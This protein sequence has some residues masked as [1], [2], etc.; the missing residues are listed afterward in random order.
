[1]DRADPS[2][3]AA[4][5]SA[6]HLRAD[7]GWRG[8]SSP[9]PRRR[10]YPH[11]AASANVCR[12]RPGEERRGGQDDGG[13]AHA[14][15]LVLAASAAPA[16]RARILCRHVAHP[17]GGDGDRGGL[18]RDARPAVRWRAAGRRSCCGRSRWRCSRS[19]PPRSTIGVASAAGPDVVFA[20]LLGVRRGPQR[21]V[22]GRRRA[23][24][25]VPASRGCAGRRG[26]CSSS[27]WRSRSRVLRAGARSI[28]P[29]WRSACPRARRC[30][31]TA[32]PRTGCRSCSPIPAFFI[33]VGGRA[34]VGVADARAAR[35]ARSLRRHA[36]DRDRR[37]DRRGRARRSR[38]FGQV[39]G[40]IVTLVV[41]IAV[42]FWGFLRASK[43]VVV[44][45]AAAVAVD[46]SSLAR[47]RPGRGLPGRSRFRARR[48]E[49]DEQALDRVGVDRDPEQD[50]TGHGNEVAEVGRAAAGRDRP[51]P[52]RRAVGRRWNAR[53]P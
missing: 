20:R 48:L 32:P 29:R 11:S 43:P 44:P 52:I 38:P 30:S 26:S 47:G 1:M 8:P 50:G 28:R 15:R 16:V 10:A 40:F 4:S 35:V 13:P 41:G 12:Q 27:A 18:R 33:L 36:A 34:V 46:A 14:H 39:T 22:P 21:A 24:P 51:Q 25:A 2:G 45:D 7:P 31:A 6:A 19:P 17:A 9:S 23:R 3:R 5:A 49:G 37:H 42:M 53:A